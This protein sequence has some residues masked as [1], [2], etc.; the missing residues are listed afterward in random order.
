LI[1]WLTVLMPAAVQ[2]ALPVGPVGKQVDGRKK[3]E[4]PTNLLKD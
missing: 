3:P 4:V 1:F 2:A